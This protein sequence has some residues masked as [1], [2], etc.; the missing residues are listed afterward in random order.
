MASRPSLHQVIQTHPLIDNH[1]HNLLYKYAACNYAKYPLEQIISEAQGVA[2][3]NAPSTLSFHRAAAQLATLYQCPSTDW[4]KLK[5]ARDQLVQSDYDGLI[6]KCLEGTH[7]LLLDDLLTDQDIEPYD[8]HDRFTASPTKRIVRIEAVAAQ[9]LS[10]IVSGGSIPP[11]SSDPASFQTLWESFSREFNLRISDAI[12]DPAV[13]GFKSVIC[14]RTGL[15]VQPTEDRDTKPLL[16]SFARTV[17]Q[18]TVSTPRVEDKLMNDWLV[19]QTLNLLKAAKAIQPNKP[20]QLHTGLGDNDIDLILSNPAHLQS[21]IAQYPEVD[22]VLLHSS[23]P[24]TREAGYLACVYP[25][26]YLDL[27]E[28]FPMV[29][30]D[31]QES[32]VR[33]SLELVP[34]TRLLWSTDGHFFPE[35]FWLANKQFRDILEKVQISLRAAS[36][37]PSM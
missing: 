20:L 11:E 12:R 22:F 25:N 5:A 13:V 15:N 16:Q 23:Y 21:V 29:S 14:Y 36:S 18:A 26:V 10:K 28:V 1:A 8:S 17:S 6:R 33:E 31:A 2:L 4:E 32:I 34:T 30:R 3:T 19:R 35:T 24:Y 7:T 37:H 9:A 27:G